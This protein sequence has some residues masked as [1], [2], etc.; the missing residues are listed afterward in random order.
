M[1]KQPSLLVIQWNYT[2]YIGEI[3]MKLF[4]SSL[5]RGMAQM[6]KIALWVD[7]KQ[8]T[9]LG[10][11]LIAFTHDEVY[12]D[13]L[14]RLLS[15]LSCPLTF[16]G[17]YINV[18]ATSPKGTLEYSH[19]IDS[20]CR[21]C[22]LAAEYHVNHIVFHYTQKGVLAE[23]KPYVKDRMI[24]NLGTILDIGKREGAEILVE[25][26]PYPSNGLP[27]CTNEEYKEL[28]DLFPN[29]CGLI[30][31]GHAYLTQ[32]PMGGFLENYG[33]RI[34]AYHF[35]NN[36]GMKDCHNSILNGKIDYEKFAVLFQK[37]TPDA[38]IVL[39]YEPHAWVSEELMERDINYVNK[40]YFS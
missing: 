9:G 14:K 36:D 37:Y 12:W 2:D 38:R 22:S 40:L 21:V 28:Y 26:L 7:Q 16:H 5:V 19:L 3:D 33:E 24:E 39:E 11:E 20:Y 29:M 4:I 23:E 8:E 6:E 1:K 35:H 31:M 10:V 34:H 25:N 17:P 27:L 13:R 15:K 18:E 30:D 32:L